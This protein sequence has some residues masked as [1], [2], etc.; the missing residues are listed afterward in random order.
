VEQQRMADTTPNLPR[1][2]RIAGW[3]SDIAALGG[4]ASIVYGIDLIY[5]PAAF[6][7]GGA[8]LLGGAW[9][10]ARTVAA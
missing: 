10:Y 1:S 2:G 8:I 5:H 6:I 3:A 9:K 7:V 4:A